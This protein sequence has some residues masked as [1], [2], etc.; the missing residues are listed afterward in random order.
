M[1]NSELSESSVPPP[2]EKGV[3][4]ISQSL[5]PPIV[6]ATLVPAEPVAIIEDAE[7]ADAIAIA[8]DE[9]CAAAVQCAPFQREYTRETSTMSSSSDRGVSS[10][11]SSSARLESLRIPHEV[12]HIDDEITL[13]TTDTT[14]NEAQLNE[15]TTKKQKRSDDVMIQCSKAY[16]IVG[17]STF[18]IGIAAI[19]GLLIVFMSKEKGSKTSQSFPSPTVALDV[20]TAA[21]SSE[22]PSLAPSCSGLFS[23]VYNQKVKQG[24][25]LFFTM[26]QSG[27]TIAVSRND[28]QA[29]GSFLEFFNL[30]D[31]EEYKTEEVYHI[32]DLHISG[33]GSTLA[34]G[35]NSYEGSQGKG[36]AVLL[37]KKLNENR[38]TPIQNIEAGGGYRG[39]VYSV[40]LSYDGL[41]VA[42]V[43]SSGHVDVFQKTNETDFFRR[44]GTRLNNDILPPIN[45][46]SKVELSGDGNRL[47]VS[48]SQQIMAFEINNETATW[49]SLGQTIQY[50]YATEMLVSHNGTTLVV[51][52]HYDFPIVVYEEWKEP[53]S[54][55]TSWH[56]VSTL[57]IPMK[58]VDQRM[59]V[60]ADGRNIVVSETL[61]KNQ[62][63]AKFFHRSG[64]A[65]IAT[66]DI[67][68]HAGKLRGIALD[69]AGEQLTVAINET[70]TAY[71]KDCGSR[72]L[73]QQP[74]QRKN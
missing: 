16:L 74:S 67:T 22:V 57:D 53:G 38:F 28:Y 54:N 61:A 23:Q 48:A 46:D 4:Y 30:E 66:Q 31:E 50:D 7:P 55:A 25:S 43:A 52:T 70:V 5:N 21:P 68:L 20:P 14:A 36:G 62:N 49:E 33:D 51:G 27:S 47:Y 45:A 1:K 56:E 65:F 59:A 11:H 35:V 42:Y 17:T 40:S 3:Q 26:D 34:V 58:G 13:E 15:G 18:L 37:F 6:A 41:T 69:P 10:Q 2:S 63:V 9:A 24:G 32:H 39:A 60:S 8:V 44:H 64:S 72:G 19:M 71:R 73:F 12:V 29:E